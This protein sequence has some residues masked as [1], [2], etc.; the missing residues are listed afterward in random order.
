V[1]Y[2]VPGVGEWWDNNGGAD[3]RIVL[4]AATPLHPTPAKRSFGLGG[5]SA[6][7]LTRVG[8]C[9]ADISVAKTCA[10]PT[11]A[12]SSLSVSPATSKRLRIS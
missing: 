11:L 5:V 7:A 3:F 9:R 12:Q 4:T 8:Q 6:T 1:R 10:Y 2:T